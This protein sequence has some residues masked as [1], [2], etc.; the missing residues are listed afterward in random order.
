MV[1]V[2]DCDYHGE[3]VAEA[4]VR[5]QGGRVR[6]PRGAGVGLLVSWERGL[7]SVVES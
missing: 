6:V 7:V 4:S 3:T 5:G 2:G 1:A